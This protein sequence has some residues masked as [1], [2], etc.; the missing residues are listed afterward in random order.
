MDRLDAVDLLLS[1]SSAKTRGWWP[2]AAAW[3]LRLELEDRLTNF[4]ASHGIAMVGVNMRSQLLILPIYLDPDEARAIIA[5]WHGLSRAG[6]H[7]AYELAPTQA[8]IVA[9]ASIVGSSFG[10]PRGDSVPRASGGAV[11]NLERTS[12]AIP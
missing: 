4:W 11:P 1:S 8:E 12:T 3:L 6:H 9:W 7:H 10:S 2:R 5:T